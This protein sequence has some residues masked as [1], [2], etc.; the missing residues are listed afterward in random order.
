MN[1]WKEKKEKR[2]KQQNIQEKKSKGKQNVAVIQY[3][4]L[5][6]EADALPLVSQTSQ[7]LTYRP[8]TDF[9]QSLV[10]SELVLAAMKP[11]LKLSI[12]R[13]NEQFVW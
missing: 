1:E 4:Q 7:D 3:L 2:L 13:N 11:V 5:V 10:S 9:S 8:M 6:H 12:H